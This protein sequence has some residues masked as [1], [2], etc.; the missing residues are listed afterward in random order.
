MPKT[1]RNVSGEDLYVPWLDRVVVVDE[2]VDVPDDDGDAYLSQTMTWA[3]ESGPAT[4][5]GGS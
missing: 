4:T 3:A 5:E 1:I 2:V